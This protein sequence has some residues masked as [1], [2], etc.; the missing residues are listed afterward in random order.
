M[1]LRPLKPCRHPGCPRVARGTYCQPHL[2]MR[3]AARPSAYAR[4]YGGKGWLRV[5]KLVLVRDR[6]R[7]RACRALLGLR[8][9]DAH[10][11]HIVPIAQGGSSSMDN[12][13]TLCAACHSSKTTREDGGFGRAPVTPPPGR[14]G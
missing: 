2:A 7:C 4:G 12:L 8:R 1:V 6:Y 10:V 5:R 3:N 9:R 11:D 13:Q 14:G